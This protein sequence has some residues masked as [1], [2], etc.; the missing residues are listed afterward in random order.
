VTKDHAGAG[1][2][3]YILNLE[4]LEKYFGGLQA[5]SAFNLRLGRGELKG[6]IGPNG[7]GKSTVFN[8]ISGLYKPTAGRVYL[9]GEEITGL[10]PDTIAAKGIAR[11]FQ[12]VKFLENRTVLETMLTAFFLRSHYNLLDAIFKTRRYRR[13]ENELTE[14]AVDYL[15][16]LG[17]DHL[18][19]INSNELPYGLQRKAS[20]AG[21]LCLKPRILLLDE[22]MAG[23]TRPEKEEL[24]DT[25]LKMKTEFNLSIILVEH[26]MKV[27]MHLCDSIAVMNNGQMIAE[28]DAEAIRSNPD[29]IKAYLGKEN[30]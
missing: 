20:I 19:D 23:L 7:A 28:G 6:L 5:V 11:T 29:V 16:R 1:G 8:L 4:N 14:K 18:K 27:I 25:I 21:T 3:H 24:C 22:P 15:A 2:N 13:M 9:E 26:D 17:I 10:R 12:I 30:R